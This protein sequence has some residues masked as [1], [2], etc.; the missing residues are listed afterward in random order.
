MQLG[1]PAAGTETK[2]E[3]VARQSAAI[4]DTARLIDLA[5]RLVHRR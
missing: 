5:Q 4:R 3:P 1:Y 2:P